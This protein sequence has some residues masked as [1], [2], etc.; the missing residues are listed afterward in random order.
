MSQDKLVSSFVDSMADCFGEIGVEVSAANVEIASW[1]ERGAPSNGFGNTFPTG[2]VEGDLVVAFLSAD[3]DDGFTQSPSS[4]WTLL[5]EYDTWAFTGKV[6]SKTIDSSDITNGGFYLTNDAS[7]TEDCT[8]VMVK[9]TGGNHTITDFSDVSKY[10]GSTDLAPS[11][12]PSQAG[13]LLLAMGCRDTTPENFTTTPASEGFTE[14]TTIESR[15]GA[16]SSGNV[17]TVW[18]KEDSGTS[19]ETATFNMGAEEAYAVLLAINPE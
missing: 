16:S 8:M 2:V 10:N 13:S 9:V 6:Y 19:S 4:G 1:N 17:M 18:Y 5:G 15:T 14:L 7:S 11:I 12:T 3:D